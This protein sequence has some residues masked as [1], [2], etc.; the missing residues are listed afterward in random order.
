MA[1]RRQSGQRARRR[2]SP[3][4]HVAETRSSTPPTAAAS[5]PVRLFV[6][7]RHPPHHAAQAA[8]DHSAA[9]RKSPSRH[10]VRA[11]PANT[12]SHGAK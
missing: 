8:L 12:V 6:S 7:I 4:R 1:S 9:R 10:N 11:T 5:Q 3:A 2:P